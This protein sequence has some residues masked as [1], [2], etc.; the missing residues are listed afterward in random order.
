MKLLTLLAIML[1]SGSYSW[2][3]QKDTTVILFDYNKYLLNTT[4]VN[5]LQ[6]FI[7]SYQ[8]EKGMIMIFGHCDSRGS[9]AY[10]EMLSE[11]RTNAVR[12]WLE[13]NGVESSN[14]SVA[15][16]LGEMQPLNQ[17]SNEDEMQLNRRVEIIWERAP[18]PQPVQEPVETPKNF[19]KETVD[20]L[21]VGDKLVLPNINFQGGLHRFMPSSMESLK[22][23][24][25]VMRE[26]A[27]LEIE[28]QGH[29]CCRAGS[30]DDG[31]DLE[32]RKYNLSAARARAVYDYLVEN[33]IEPSRMKYRGF[34]GR[35]PLVSP[36]RSEADRTTNRRV[37]IQ[38]LK[39]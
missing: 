5:Q 32:T 36:E 15:K 27:T 28:I 30:E 18:E 8:D 11:Q 38:V 17:N 12:S 16:G 2:A 35:F 37:E 22:E 1:F 25:E 13:I 3:Q 26:N 39:R 9:E 21:K 7:E 4:A 23:L 14:I 10:N 24:L 6:S 33:G 29:I 34:A 20:S 31:I 19:S